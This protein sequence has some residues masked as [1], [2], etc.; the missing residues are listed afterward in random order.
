MRRPNILFLLTDNQRADPLGCAGHPLLRTPHL[1]RLAARGVRFANAFATTPVCAA[2]RASYLCGVYERRLPVHVP[3]PAPGGG[4]QRHQL[5]HPAQAVG[6]PHRLRRLYRMVSGVDRNI[7][8]IVEALQRRALLDDTVI[9]FASDHGM[10]YGERGLSD[11][12][13]LNEEPIRVPLIV[14]DPRRRR[15][16]QIRTE[17]A[18]NIDVSPTILEPAGVGCPDIVQG[19]S[20]VPLLAESGQP[21]RDAFFCEHLF[22]RADIPKSEGIRTTEWKYIRYFE[23]DPVHEELY[24]LS[25]DPHESTNLAPHPTHAER[26]QE[27]STR[28]DRMRE[29]AAG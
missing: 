9:I 5:P 28:C 4:V 7:G 11:C 23:Q 29:A 22:D 8:L 17:L 6:V 25:A 21:W 26:L 16:A 12:W 3:Y 14:T 18:L 19:R 15:G 20:L 1:D 10:Y 27:M 24:D 2:S 13:H